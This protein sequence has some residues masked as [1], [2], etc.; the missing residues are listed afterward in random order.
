MNF[1]F[2]A[3]RHLYFLNGTNIPGVTS[4]I[5]AANL[6]DD[7][8]FND[9]SRERGTAVHLACFY[10]LHNDLA[11]E[12]LDYEILGY[13]QG[14]AKFLATSGFKP[15]LRYCE[16]PRYHPT[17][18]YG[19][20]PDLLGWL[21]GRYVLIDIKSGIVGLSAQIQ[22]AAYEHFPE[23]AALTPARFALRLTAAGDG[24]LTDEFRDPDD[25]NVFLSAIN[26]ANYK[27]R[28]ERNFC[29]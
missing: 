8:W 25:F 13:V 12:S 9:E 27:K 17:L 29:Y 1:H 4:C 3:E 10:L 7:R 15:D 23:I 22:T 18:L 24:Y 11:W 20:T 19:G 16:V 21:N 26:V 14:F 5:K 28:Y 6:I 2:D